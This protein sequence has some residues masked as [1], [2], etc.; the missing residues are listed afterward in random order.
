VSGY[1]D[2]IGQ[3]IGRPCDE[4]SRALHLVTGVEQASGEGWSRKQIA[5][6]GTNRRASDGDHRAKHQFAFRA[7]SRELV[8]KLL[9]N[10]ISEIAIC[11]M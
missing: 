11:L 8:S 7:G 6:A 2:R 5:L 9:A 3:I 1:A 10:A 4:I